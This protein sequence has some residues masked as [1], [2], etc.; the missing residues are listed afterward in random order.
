MG[1]RVGVQVDCR[2]REGGEGGEGGAWGSTVEASAR[3]AM[4]VLRSTWLCTA[5]AA[6]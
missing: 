5:R 1:A 4:V 3:R 6:M 2:E